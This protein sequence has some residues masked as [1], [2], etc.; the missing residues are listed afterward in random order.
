[1]LVQTTQDFSFLGQCKNSDT[2]QEMISKKF[3]ITPYT[4]SQETDKMV[5]VWVVY[6]PAWYDISTNTPMKF[7]QFNEIQ[8]KVIPDRYKLKLE[9]NMSA[10]EWYWNKSL[11]T[12]AAEMWFVWYVIALSH[13]Q[14]GLDDNNCVLSSRLSHSNGY[15]FVNYMP[16]EKIYVYENVIK[17]IMDKKID[18]TIYIKSYRDGYISFIQKPLIFERAALSYP[19]AFAYVELTKNNITMYSKSVFYP[20]GEPWEEKYTNRLVWTTQKSDGSYPIIVQIK[21]E[22]EYYK[23][24]SDLASWT[25]NSPYYQ[26][27]LQEFQKTIDTIFY[28][29]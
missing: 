16:P 25:E 2:V 9:T 14:T 27:S 12:F 7:K 4:W 24:L 1:M 23:A 29:K 26:Q 13:K 18:K 6:D 21:N 19:T 22:N 28:S 15:S 17:P 8:D 5:A 11:Q 3:I 10:N 20:Y